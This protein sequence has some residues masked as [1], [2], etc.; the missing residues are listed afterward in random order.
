MYKG[1]TFMVK[2]PADTPQSL[3]PVVLRRET[4]PAALGFATTA[5]LADIAGLIGQEE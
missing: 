2:Q 4:D 3:E 5:D 1:Q